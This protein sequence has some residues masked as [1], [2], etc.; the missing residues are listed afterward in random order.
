MTTRLMIGLALALA[1][2]AACTMDGNDATEPDAG[3]SVLDP[4]DDI[5]PDI[6]TE[7]VLSRAEEWVS[8]KLH[9]CQSANHAR[10]YDSACSTYCERQD[11]SQWDPYRSDCSGFV[12]WAWG[13]GAPGR[14]TLGFAPFETDIT[15][16][17]D[18][19]DLQPGDAINNSDHI[20]LFKAWTERGHE[21]TFLEEP[22]CSSATPYAHQVTVSVSISGTQVYVP[23]NGM[24]FTAIH[25]TGLTA[26]K[27]LT[28]PEDRIGVSTWGPQRIDLFARNGDNTLEHRYFADSQWSAWQKLGTTKLDSAPAA[29][30]WAEG[31]IDVFA[32]G[33][34]NHLLHKWFADNTWHDFEDLGGD[35]T[36]PP[37]AVSMSP[38][39]IDV[40][41]RDSN[42]KL[43]HKYLRSGAGWSGWQELGDEELDG[44]PSASVWKESGR[45][46][47]FARAAD[48]NLFHVHHQYGVWSKAVK[49]EA[50]IVA[51]PAVTA[52]ADGRLDIFGQAKN[53]SVMHRWY[54]SKGWSD[55]QNLGGTILSPPTAVS[56]SANR[57]DVF[58]RGGQDL[59]V[60]RY[61]NGAAGWSDWEHQGTMPQ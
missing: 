55:W 12:S 53:G 10:D 16:T 33:T 54:S 38:N 31:R 59:D 1:G 7:T 35:L 48:N 49:I 41:V 47:V 32:R 25:Y 36:S 44:A 56:W 40:F 13:L 18:A 51:G 2:T 37:S 57:I 14:T 17:I 3:V 4:T 34:N 27:P 11:N 19:I 61:F 60:H 29:V 46:D 22:G 20:M 8:A 15:K 5:T 6:A 42:N 26:T 23:Y 39:S 45:I 28:N 43:A 50:G 24:T 30:A 52:W 21:A 9:Y 58:A